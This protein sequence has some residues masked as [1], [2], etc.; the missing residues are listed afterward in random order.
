MKKL[1]FHQYEYGSDNYGVLIHDP[2][3]KATACVDVGDATKAIGALEEK[4]WSLTYIW[5]THHHPDH[6]DGLKELKIKT[7]AFVYG[8][9]IVSQ[10]I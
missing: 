5:I 3:S 2:Q 1:L 8:P 7:G 9:K 4:K 6:T 10:H